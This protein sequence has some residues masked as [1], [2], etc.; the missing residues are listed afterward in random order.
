MSERATRVLLF[1][2]FAIQ[3]SA[4]YRIHAPLSMQFLNRSA[5][6]LRPKQ[7]YIDWA[8]S[9]DDGPRYQETMNE[10]DAFTVFLGPDCDT[11]DEVQ[12][13]VE[14]HFDAF[15][16]QWLEEW[17]TDPSLWPKRRTRAMFRDWFDVA[18]HTMVL[19]TVDQ[20]FELD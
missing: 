1:E 7:P 9:L 16:D 19:D 3:L 13:F 10:P 20:P 15:F 2:S 12:K 8:N 14:K 5:I 11:V 6:I 18:I 17:C 4:L